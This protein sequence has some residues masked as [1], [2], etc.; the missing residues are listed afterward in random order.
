MCTAGALGA[1]TANASSAVPGKVA[2]RTALTN[3]F[4]ARKGPIPGVRTNASPELTTIKFPG[5]AATHTLLV[6]KGYKSNLG[7]YYTY[8]T[9]KGLT[10]W[11]KPKGID[12]LGHAT[13]LHRPSAAFYTNAS[14]DYVIVVWQGSGSKQ[15]IW[16]SIGVAKA[17]GKLLWG[18]ETAIPGVASS[19]GPTV[20]KVLYSGALFLTW[21]APASDSI[22]YMILTPKAGG[23]H[24]GSAKT[25]PHGALTNTSPTV[26]DSTY[27]PRRAR[28]FV[29]WRGTPLGRPFFEYTGDPTSASPT[30]NDEI[31]FPSDRESAASPQAEP[32]G[33]GGGAPLLVS[34]CGKTTDGILYVLLPRIGPLGPQEIV[35]SL[36]TDKE[37]PGLDARMIA[38]TAPNGQ[39]YY[40]LLK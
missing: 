10:K 34:Y 16:Y 33:H 8:T 6:Y 7:L 30:W 28:L 39:V 3:A 40:N 4:S 5:S 23:I 37:A 13:T 25:L 1:S 22:N 29:F 11:A 9:N 21:K 17:G 19:D 14:G 32:V 2:V 36:K 24:L 20:F 35:P 15:G 18:P 31:G 38:A 26:A 27:A 12:S